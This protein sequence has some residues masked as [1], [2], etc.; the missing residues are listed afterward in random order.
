MIS[1]LA[2]CCCGDYIIGGSLQRYAV[3]GVWRPKIVIYLLN[4]K[5]GKS[6]HKLITILNGSFSYISLD[7]IFID[8]Y[9]RLQ[10]IT[11]S[12]V[13]DLTYSSFSC[14]C[15]CDNVSLNSFDYSFNLL[16]E[17]ILSFN[18]LSFYSV[19]L[20]NFNKYNYVTC[21]RTYYTSDAVYNCVCAKSF[22]NFDIS[23]LDVFKTYFNDVLLHPTNY[24]W[25]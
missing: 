9:T 7:S 13:P 24:S 1:V 22:A 3:S 16:T 23:N 19:S 14:G 25:T 4:T 8:K 10:D 20:S 18:M 15:Y 5:T 17:K 2:N 12:Y 21:C 6:H 11:Y